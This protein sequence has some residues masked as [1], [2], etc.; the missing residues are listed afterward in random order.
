[1]QEV[2]YPKSS[3]H[4]S[5]YEVR[6]KNHENIIIEFEEQWKWPSEVIKLQKIDTC[7]FESSYIKSARC[8]N[9]LIHCK[10]SNHNLLQVLHFICCLSKSKNVILITDQIT[11]KGLSILKKYKVKAVFA[12]ENGF[13]DVCNFLNAANNGQCTIL[14]NNVSISNADSAYGS[15]ELDIVHN[16][17]IIEV[18]ILYYVSMGLTTSQISS[19]LFRS[20]HTIKNHKVNIARKAG[21][22]GCSQLFKLVK[23]LENAML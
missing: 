21:I 10:F 19:H 15:S 14:K 7:L 2:L 23:D 13:L 6:I 16:L 22:E 8:S 9:I 5:I 12:G 20:Y 17:S 11:S 1:M 3:K 4:L 18:E